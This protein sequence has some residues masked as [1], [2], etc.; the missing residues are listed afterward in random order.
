LQGANSSRASDW[1]SFGII[2]Y[3]MLTGLPPFMH[4]KREKLYQ[5]I[6]YCEPNV[7]FP[8]LTSEAQDLLKGLLRKDPS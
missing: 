5:K 7:D 4:K 6:K 3:E 2:V 1:W 8:Y